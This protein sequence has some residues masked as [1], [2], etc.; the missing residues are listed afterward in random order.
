MKTVSR[1]FRKIFINILLLLVLSNLSSCLPR[2]SEAVLEGVWQG[3][4]ECLYSIQVWE[5][6]ALVYEDLWEGSTEITL[7]INSSTENQVR[8]KWFWRDTLEASLYSA[9][10]P[11]FSFSG[12]VTDGSFLTLTT[13]EM[14]EDPVRTHYEASLSFELVQGNLVGEGTYSED[15]SSEETRVLIEISFE[16]VM[17]SKL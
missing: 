8:G 5:N 2:S 14:K 3:L 6:D 11:P 1:H 13:D 12:S 4:G 9:P 7:E 15:G 10:S 16:A 17:L